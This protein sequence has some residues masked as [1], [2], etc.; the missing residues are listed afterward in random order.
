MPKSATQKEFSNAVLSTFTPLM[1]LEHKHP[2]APSVIREEYIIPYFF[3]ATHIRFIMIRTDH[4][5]IVAIEQS[6]S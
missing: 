4:I 6:L 1:I 3:Y 2:W 5:G